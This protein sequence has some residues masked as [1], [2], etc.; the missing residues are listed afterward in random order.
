M[1]NARKMDRSLKL[2]VDI[3]ASLDIKGARELSSI[4]LSRLNK[5]RIELKKLATLA[6]RMNTLLI[7]QM[8]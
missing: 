5:L 1:N 8:F 2:L 6:K 4:F 7:I 3:L